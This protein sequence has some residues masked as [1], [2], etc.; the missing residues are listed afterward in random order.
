MSPILDS[1]GSVKGFGWGAFAS[2]ISSYEFVATVV[3]TTSNITQ[4]TFSSIPSTYRH[5]E[6]RYFGH[7][8]NNTNTNASAALTFNGDTSSNYTRNAD[9]AYLVPSG[10]GYREGSASATSVAAIYATLGGTYSSDQTNSWNPGVIYI[11]DYA[12][13]NKGKACSIIGGVHYNYVHGND[14]LDAAI[15]RLDYGFWKNT[16]SVINRIDI[17]T[18]G[19]NFTTNT[20]FSLYGVK[21]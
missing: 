1:I 4:I 10:G 13:T 12:S 19:Y 2:S 6:I 15:V 16:T 21:S 11:Q 20:R 18:S 7:T 3:A 17:I 8:N 9:N 5:L 14:S